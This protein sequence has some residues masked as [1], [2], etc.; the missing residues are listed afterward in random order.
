M[1]FFIGRFLEITISSLH[2][3]GKKHNLDKKW[4]NEWNLSIEDLADNAALI[5]SL[6]FYYEYNSSVS[7]LKHLIFQII[8]EASEATPN[9]ISLE[10]VQ[11]IINNNL[12][13]DDKVFLVST[14]SVLELCLL[15][16]IKHHSEIYDNDYFNFEMIYSRFN[17]FANK[18]SSMKNIDR[19]VAL[20]A[21]EKLK[22]I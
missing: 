4:I 9:S 5:R 8:I 12:T 11:K 7:F 13:H 16:S 22:V 17:K 1:I 10:I 6:K 20:K 14:L 18:S 15:I 19:E 2:F 21:F 3:K